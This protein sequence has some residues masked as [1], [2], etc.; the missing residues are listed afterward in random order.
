MSQPQPVVLR[1]TVFDP[2]LDNDAEHTHALTVSAVRALFSVANRPEVVSL[3]GGMPN[4]ADLPRAAIGEAVVA[5]GMTETSLVPLDLEASGMDFGDPCS[6][7]VLH[8]KA[9]LAGEGPG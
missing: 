7:P 4:I 5:P 8:A 2:W 1:D 3:A 9:C 6:R